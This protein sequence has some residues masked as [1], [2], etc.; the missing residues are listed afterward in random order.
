[1]NAINNLSFYVYK[2]TRNQ[3][4]SSS[5]GPMLVCLSYYFLAELLTL[6]IPQQNETVNGMF[7][8]YKVV[9]IRVDK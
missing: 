3:I 6:R 2:I 1:M 5:G 8:L 4:I 7:T 9:L